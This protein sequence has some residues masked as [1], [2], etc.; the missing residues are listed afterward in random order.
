[1]PLH[2]LFDIFVWFPSPL[3]ILI[4]SWSFFFES[5][6]FICFDS[7]FQF[8]THILSPAACGH[9]KCEMKRRKISAMKKYNNDNDDETKS[10]Y[11]V[12]R[13]WYFVTIRYTQSKL[14]TM[15]TI[16]QKKWI[17]NVCCKSVVTRQAESI[18]NRRTKSLF[19]YCCYILMDYYSDKIR[20]KMKLSKRILIR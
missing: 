8:S 4:L 7:N 20:N 6:K 1:M 16:Q 12:T 11:G 3:R 10:C 9:N 13:L 14:I 15:F 17:W 19:I 5:I 18:R 2:S